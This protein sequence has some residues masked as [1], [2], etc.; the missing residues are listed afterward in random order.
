MTTTVSTN[1][2]E[3]LG[4][5]GA[6]KRSGRSTQ[7]VQRMAL[8]GKIRVQLPPGEKP[9]YNAADIDALMGQRQ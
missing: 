9:L 3:W 2:P 8:L 4:V 5:W 6:V 1:Q 7:W